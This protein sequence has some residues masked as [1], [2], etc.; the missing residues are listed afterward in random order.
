MI[1]FSIRLNNDV[2]PDRWL[3]LVTLAES[4]GFDHIWVSHDLFWRSAPVLV[5]A[6]AQRTSR[7][8]LG[9][10]VTNPCSAHPAELAMH[11]ATLQEFSDGR[12]LLGLGAGADEFLAWAGIDPVQ[13][14]VP[15]TREALL[16]IRAL[17]EGGRP[18]DVPGSG[19]GW[20]PEAY[21][22]TEPAHTPIYLGGMGPAMLRLAGE[23]ADGALPLLYPP[24]R[25]PAALE[26][27]GAGA[28]RSGRELEA[29]DIAACVWCSIDADVDRARWAL[30]QK[31]AYY[32]SSFSAHL[33]SAAGLSL[34]DFLPIQ[35]AMSAGDHNLAASLVSP[36]M[37]SLGIAGDASEVA[38]RCRK[39]VD[40]GAR[41][42][43]F[44]PPLGPDPVTAVRQL[45]EVVLPALRL[46]ARER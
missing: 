32:G 33:L 25:F 35:R 12:F 43:S 46:R 11:A 42:V 2:E 18:A 16:G 20:R 21:L 31:I 40:S 6:A 27:I 36:A 3:E 7:I 34:S 15:R 23:V 19:A 13:R 4:L 45:G 26:E 38:A 14:P 24:E 30:A 17:L 44:G 41:H 10:G 8:R 22:R 9:I 39:L 28:R 37:L 1:R 5:A 29:I